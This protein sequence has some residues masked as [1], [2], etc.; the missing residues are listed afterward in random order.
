MKNTDARKYTTEQQQLLRLKAVDMVF[1]ENY[2]QRATAKALGVSRQH[3]VKWCKAFE[4]GGYEALK[5]GRRGRRPQEQMALKPWQCA[6]I[7]NLI[8]DRTPDQL[9]L[10]FVLWERV[11]VR[12]LIKEKFGI[13]L[14]LRTVGEYL[15]RWN[16]TPQRPVERAYEQNPKT[17]DKWLN[18]EYPAI[19]ARAQKEGALIFWGDETGVQNGS[20]HS[21]SYAPIGKTPEIK[22]TGKKL[23]I[24]M[25][26]AITNRGEVRFMIYAG[27]MNQAMFISFLK[28]LISTSKQKVFFITDNLKVHHGKKV[29]A[30]VAKH[31]SQIELFFIPSYSPELNPDEYLNRDLKKNVHAS[32][33]PRTQAELKN[34]L[35]S[36]MRKLQKLPERVMG[37]FNS[38]HIAYAAA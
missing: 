20:N 13:T 28:R 15:R 17:M 16:L 18:E 36:F 37:Y 35:L 33:T 23:R 27:K 22:K 38:K 21:R 9:K 1:K 26:S 8:C 30:W 11:G 24:N 5:L 32:R 34:N 7:V 12:E 2:T 3:V 29:A 4:N 31:S 14:A 10:P 25:I 6:T 19:K